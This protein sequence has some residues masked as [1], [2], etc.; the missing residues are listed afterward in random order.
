M[1]YDLGVADHDVRMTALDV[2]ADLPGRIIEEL[3]ER[4]TLV[5][6]IRLNHA[7]AA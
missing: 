4:Q 6:P 1:A 7:L 5:C 3:I 2:D